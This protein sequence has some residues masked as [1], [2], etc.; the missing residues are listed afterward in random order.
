MS[1]FGWMDS[2]MDNSGTIYVSS[3]TRIVIPSMM[4]RV[5]GNL[6]VKMVPWPVTVLM[7][8]MPLEL[9]DVALDYVHP[10]PRP[11]RSVSFSAVEKP[12]R[13]MRPT[14][15]SDSVSLPVIILC[16]DCLRQNLSRFKP[17]P[18]VFDR[19]ADLA[20]FVERIEPD[21]TLLRFAGSDSFLRRLQ[22]VVARI[23]EQVRQRITDGLDDAPVSSVS[24]AGDEELNVL[25]DFRRQVS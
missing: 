10:D 8:T 22:A 13:K 23:S 6:S 2:R 15:S 12:G 9:F 18:V 17:R 5:S 16:L 4:A 1:A 20:A 3:P 19:D 7:V 21:R 25:A 24:F 11:D 14:W